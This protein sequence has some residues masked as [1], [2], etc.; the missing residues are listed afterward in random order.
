LGIFR[1]NTTTN[2]ITQIVIFRMKEG[3]YPLNRVKS[4]PAIIG[5]GQETMAE[6]SIES[7]LK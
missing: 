3:A 4:I 2:P 7:L 1:N 5:P 6:T